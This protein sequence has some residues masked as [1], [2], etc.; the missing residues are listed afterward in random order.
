[1]SECIF[2]KHEVLYEQN[3]VGLTGLKSN[4]NWVATQNGPVCKGHMPK[5]QDIEDTA[6]TNLSQEF[7]RVPHAHRPMPTDR[8]RKNIQTKILNAGKTQ[9]ETTSLSLDE[10]DVFSQQAENLY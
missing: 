9:P 8:L 10:E 3:R 5:Y 1:M 4:E 6:R 7:P 2:N